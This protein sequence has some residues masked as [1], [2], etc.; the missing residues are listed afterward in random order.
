MLGSITGLA[1]SRIHK[2]PLLRKLRD[3]D[4]VDTSFLPGVDSTVWAV[5]AYTFSS[6]ENLAKPIKAETSDS[7]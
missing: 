3:T 1:D 5:A 2:D 7:F 4:Q 6:Q